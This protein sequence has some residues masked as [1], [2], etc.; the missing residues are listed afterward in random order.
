MDA[1]SGRDERLRTCVLLAQAM[2]LSSPV[3]DQLAA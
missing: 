3:V 2:Q 1:A